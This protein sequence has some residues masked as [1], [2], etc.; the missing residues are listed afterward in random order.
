MKRVDAIISAD[1]HLTEKEH[2]PVCWIESYWEA[3][4]A[5]VDRIL[6]LVRRWDRGRQI[7][8]HDLEDDPWASGGLG[9]DWE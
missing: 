6:R 8:Y 5:A 9:Y 2:Q 3:Q 4:A 7:G 1:W